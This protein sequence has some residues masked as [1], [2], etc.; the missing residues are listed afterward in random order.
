MH[1]L[2]KSIKAVNQDQN[3]VVGGKSHSEETVDVLLE[4]LAKKG[5]RVKLLDD[6]H[7]PSTKE[8]KQDKSIE[9]DEDIEREEKSSKKK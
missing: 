9:S 7:T 1:D 8:L 2:G 5:K 3:I 4:K 6:T